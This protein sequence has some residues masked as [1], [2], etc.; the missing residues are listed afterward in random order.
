MFEAP[1]D[2]RTR[3]ADTGRGDPRLLVSCDTTNCRHRQDSIQLGPG[4]LNHKK[5]A[6]IKAESLEGNRADKPTSE[7]REM[8]LDKT[9][10]RPM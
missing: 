7:D 4:W 10:W 8:M 1:V 9:A 3:R 2:R 5:L 6:E